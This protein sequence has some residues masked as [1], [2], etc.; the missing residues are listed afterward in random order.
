MDRHGNDAT[1][2]ATFEESGANRRG[3]ITRKRALA[4]IEIT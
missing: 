3:Y 1:D 2:L 4:I